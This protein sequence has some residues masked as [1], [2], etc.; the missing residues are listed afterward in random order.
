MYHYVT[1]T[2]SLKITVQNHIKK[3]KIAKLQ[4]IFKNEAIIK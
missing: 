3:Y 2:S 1:K 4:V